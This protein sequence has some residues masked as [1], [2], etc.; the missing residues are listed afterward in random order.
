MPRRRKLALKYHPDKNQDKVEWASKKF[1]DVAEAYEVLSD[2]EKRG[3]YDQ[4]GEEGLKHGAGNGDGGGFPGGGGG[5]GGG[6]PG[7]FRQ[8]GGGGGGT[9]FHFEAGDAQRTFDDF[10]GKGTPGGALIRSRPVQWLYRQGQGLVRHPRFLS[11][12]QRLKQLFRWLS[13][14]VPEYSSSYGGQKR[15]RDDMGQGRGQSRGQGRTRGASRALVF[16][17]NPVRIAVP[18]R[19]QNTWN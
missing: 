8:G 19:R 10:F 15:K 16:L 9:R 13:S 3:I 1:Q 7:G 12:T 5:F 14:G 18:S 2:S 17:V 4:Y 11:F 6:F